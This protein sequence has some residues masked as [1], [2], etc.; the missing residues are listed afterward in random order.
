MREQLSKAR[1]ASPPLGT[2]N[3]R[4]RQ[5]NIS[6]RSF[7]VFCTSLMVAAPYGL[8]LT[9]KARPEDVAA[10]LGKVIRPPI[11]WLHFQDCTGCTESLLQTSHPGF[12][13]LILNVISL[14]YHE[15]LMA[16]SGLQ[17][18]QALEEA[19]EK[20]SGKYILVV[21]GSIPTRD[22]GIYMKLAGRPAL[23]VLAEIGGKAA[24]IIAI[25]SCAAWGGIPSADPDPTG[26]VGVADLLPDHSII[27]IPGCPPNPYT[28]LGVVLQY[29]ADGTLPETDEQRRP[30]FAFDREIHEHCPRRAH[31]DAGNF[32]KVYGDAGHR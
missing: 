29:A 3:E 6:R 8:A 15:T 4:L 27:N 32:V 16:G 20:Y 31:F 17:A 13:D 28:M 2:I 18:R 12:A 7:L 23:D 19:A 30:K 14:E 22:H 1:K 10:V 5:G 21:E 26:A 9:D 24:A 25:G 11:I